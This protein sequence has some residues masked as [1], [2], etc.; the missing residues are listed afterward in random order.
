MR[1]WLLACTLCATPLFSADHR[2]SANSEARHEGMR[3]FFSSDLAATTATEP[4][5][6]PESTASWWD[7][8]YMTG[9][10]GGARRSMA[11]AGVTIDAA[12][13]TDVLGNP[14]GGAAK[15]FAYAGS[16][17]VSLN[18][19]FTKAGITGF[20]FY[21]SVCWRTGTNLSA[22]KIHNQFTVSQLYGSQTVRLNELYFKESLFDKRIVLKAGRLDAGNDFLTSPLYWQYVN[23]AFDG[24][25]VAIFFNIPFTA[26]P[27]ATWGAFAE[28]KPWK[29]FS[30]KFAVY[31]AN[32]KIQK[33][34]YHGMNFTFSST[35]GVVW[36]S[37]WCYLANQGKESHGMPGNY[38]VGVFYLTGSEKKFS[39]GSEQGDPG[40]YILLDQMIYRHGDHTSKRG[41]TPFLTLFFQP[42]NRNLFPFFT[43][44]GL[45]YHGP[46]ESR[47][48]DSISLGVAYGSYSSDLNAVQR[49]K[50]VESQGAETVL[51]V[52]YWARINKWFYITPDIQYI[53]HPKG[54]DST[55]NALVLGFQLG[56]DHW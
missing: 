7:K 32:S 1:Y 36:I 42:K 17:G 43:D 6:A 54:L 55:P 53:I 11:K 12:Y 3:A 45:V 2:F 47:P 8:R 28:F 38:K 33:N 46:F 29:E 50:G 18:A 41:L 14:V 23:N 15:G 35:N 9:D 16:F 56:L 4:Q 34:K 20:E 30:T 25:P 10:W 26:Y 5:E 22:K 24:N 49:K 44:A 27:N 52:N 39:G 48:H 19:N 13:V 51:E 40:F 37:E 21:S 31:N